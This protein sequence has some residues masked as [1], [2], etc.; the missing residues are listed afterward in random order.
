MK[1]LIAFLTVFVF[2]AYNSPSVK[3][4][5]CKMAGEFDESDI[6]I[7]SKLEERVSVDMVIATE[8]TGDCDWKKN[9][10]YMKVKFI[11]GAK[12]VSSSEGATIFKTSQKHQLYESLVKPDDFGQ[13]RMKFNPIPDGG[14]YKL[15]FTIMHKDK[16]I[17]KPVKFNFDIKDDK[18]YDNH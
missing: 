15:E 9:E 10:V 11:S 13:F 16:A 18:T 1:I 17:S 8:N 3:M 14:L 12:E 7:T 6:K 4:P 5:D 2:S